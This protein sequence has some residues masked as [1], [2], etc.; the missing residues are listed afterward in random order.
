MIRA[1]GQLM[2]LLQEM[3]ETHLRGLY[4]WGKVDFHVPEEVEKLPGQRRQAYGKY[5]ETVSIRFG[6]FDITVE[7]PNEFPPL[8]RVILTGPG[9]PLEIDSLDALALDQI[10]KRIRSHHEEVLCNG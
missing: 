1:R 8:G 9:D 2:R 3:F 7:S 6:V 4:H 10:G 5:R